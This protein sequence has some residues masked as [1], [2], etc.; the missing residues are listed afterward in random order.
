MRRKSFS[1]MKCPVAQSLERVGE[2]WSILIMRDALRGL[3]RFDEFQKSLDIAPNILSRRLND[4]VEHGLLEKRRYCDAPPRDEYV[5][6]EIGRDFRSVV[7][8]MLAWG[9]R[10]FAPDGKAVVLMNTETGEEADPVLVDRITGKPVSDPAFKTAR[11]PAADE[12]TPYPYS[13]P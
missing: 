9:N 2:W 1:E 5:P 13:R 4:L 3:S 11:G 12:T 10:H 7:L 8:A 6:T